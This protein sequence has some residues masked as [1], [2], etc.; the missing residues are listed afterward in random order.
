METGTTILPPRLEVLQCHVN[1]LK[2][3]DFVSLCVC[4]MS[5]LTFISWFYLLD[6]K[7]SVYVRREARKHC[8]TN[9]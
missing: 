2:Q 8:F 9:L 5:V 6:I 1:G 4:L 3:M 7:M